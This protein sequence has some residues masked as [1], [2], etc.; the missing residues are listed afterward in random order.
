MS[1]S[2]EHETIIIGAGIAGLSAALHLAERCLRPLMLEADPRFVGGRL[3]GGEEVEV[4]GWKFRLEHGVHGIWA[5]YRNFQAMLARHNLRP[6]MVP[7]TEESW[8]FQRELDIQWAPVGSAIRH[9]WFPAPFHY[10][11]LFLRPRFLKILTYE[12]WLFLFQVLGDLLVFTGIDPFAENLPM[13][14]LRLSDMVYYWPAPLRSFFVGLARNGLTARP[15]EIPLSGFVAFLRFYTLLRR[16]TW[17]FGYLPTDGGT[18]VSEPLAARVTQLG[19]E[20][21]LG[22]CVTRLEQGDGWRVHWQASD[23]TSGMTSA[24][25]VI[26]ALDS[27][28]TEKLLRASPHFNLAQ[29]YF[30]ASAET[31]VARFWFDR[32]P[33]PGPEAGIFTGEFVSDNFFW[34]DRLYDPY[35]VWHRKT[36]GSAL[37]VHFYGPPELLENSDPVLLGFAL[38]EVLGSFPELRGHVLHKHLQRNPA[39]HTLPSVGPEEQHLGIVTPWPN[40]YCC[41]DWVRHPSPAFFLERACVTGV[42]AANAVLQER[43]LTPWPLLDYLPPEPLAKGIGSL[44]RAGR[45]LQQRWRGHTPSKR[46]RGF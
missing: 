10:I 1:E 20:I 26:L 12:D 22:H 24:R 7:A 6:V 28:S 35:R 46:S 8:Y 21:R 45:R 32:L 33:R 5:P 15:D 40:L 44:V 9:S 27:A 34:L 19:G 43:C 17:E 25:Q 39:S 13:E 23:G 18:S 31:A 41:G 36:G 14:N 4:N 37:E 3:A 29:R 38:H 16:D 42:E 30:P 2:F 11:Q